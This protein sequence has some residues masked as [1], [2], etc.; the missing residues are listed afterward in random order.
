MQQLPISF[1]LFCSILV[2]NIV[3]SKF[4]SYRKIIAP[5]NNILVLGYGDKC[6]IGRDKHESLQMEI[7]ELK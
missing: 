6:G 7:D 3:S 5:T 2:L 1:N 4:S